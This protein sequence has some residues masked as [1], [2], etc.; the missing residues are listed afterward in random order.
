MSENSQ[1]KIGVIGSGTM[2][3]GIAQICVQ[4]GYKVTLQDIKAPQLEAAHAQ[5]IKFIRRGAE[6]GQYSPE[7]GEAAVSRLS[8]TTDLAEAMKDT[9][10]VIEAIFENMAAKKEL[11]SKLNEFCP[12]DTIFAS[13][14][15]G[16]SITELGAASGRPEQF[17]GMHFFNP[18]PLM[19]LVEVIRG[20]DTRPEVVEAAANLG[21]EI[22]KTVVICDDA[23]NFIVNRINRPVSLECQLMVQEG[24][25]AQNI[26][27]ALRL[28]AGFKMGPLE[29][30]DLSGLEIGL[31]VTENTLKEFGDPK[32]RPVPLVRK[33]V[34]AGNLGK[35]TG[36]GFYLYPPGSEG[37]VPRQPDISLPR[38]VAPQKIGVAGE[39]VEARRWRGKL[40]QGG[41]EPVDLKQA[42]L[43]IICQDPGQDY[44]AFFKE[45]AG[46]TEM[47]TALVVATPF[48]SPTEMGSLVERPELTFSL[49]CPLPFIHDTFFEL[50]L[51]LET[52]PHAAA[53]ALALLE[54]LKYHLIVTPETPTGVTLRVICA[55]INEAAFCLQEG[56]ASTE[57]IDNALKLGMN[58]GMGPFQYADKMGVDLVLKTLDY[59]QSETGDPRY[60]PAHI[61]RRMVRARHFGQEVGKGF[62]E[63]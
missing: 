55:M 22:G 26:D 35:K 51:G 3:A 48:V 25:A 4:A 21:R 49:F 13:N 40:A 62:Y 8:S 17:V 12:E 18:V 29:T 63:Y 32:Y 56:L 60:R 20:S 53:G 45:T 44:K 6:K 43:V 41:F 59:L 10:W 2:G 16:L 27:K 14:T 23:P 47:K 57:D 39:G 52:A 15:S 24:L 9:A 37:P 34:R 11:Y 7:E 31:S 36:K 61:L 42:E 33:L 54:A 50:A 28:G 58:Y 38:V 1:K 5:I 19:K 46:R 30:G